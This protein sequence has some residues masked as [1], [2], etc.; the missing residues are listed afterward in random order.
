MAVITSLADAPWP[1]CCP[2]L[3]LDGAGLPAPSKVRLKLCTLDLRFA[4][5]ALGRLS[6]RDESSARAMPGSAFPS[7]A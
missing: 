6:A 4:R 3:V 7:S 1:C 2:I 5:G